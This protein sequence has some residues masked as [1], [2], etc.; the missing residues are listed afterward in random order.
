MGRNILIPLDG[1]PQSES[2]LPVV[3]R[4]AES[5]DHIH[6]VHVLAQLPSPV[7]AT[8]VIVL[9]EQAVAYLDAVRDQWLA[10]RRGMNL[11]SS[12]DIASTILLHVLEKNIDLIAMSTHGRGGLAKFF[13][14]S[15]AAAVVREAQLPVLLVRPDIL[16]VDR[17]IRKILVAVEGRETPKDLLESVKSLVA[18]ADA[19]ITLLQAVPTVA[20]PAPLW[21]SPLTLSLRNSPEHYLQE[22]ADSLNEQGYSARP[23]LA[24]GDPAE[25]ILD[26]A[27]RSGVDLIAL[28]THGRTGMERLVAGSVA[29]AVL[30][31]STV[32]ILLQKPLVVHKSILTRAGDEPC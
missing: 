26:Q 11:V 12:G 32:P 20:D 4:I 15:V 13:L 23:K 24:K 3:Q 25:A 27:A 21:A 10:G 1:T 30:R 8:Q 7:G 28:A 9:H 29:E 5:G 31:R 14:G 19:E 22:L 6:L 16:R 17:P 18:G 2:V